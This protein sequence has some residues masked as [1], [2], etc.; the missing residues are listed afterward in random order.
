[1]NSILIAGNIVKRAF[2]SRKELAVML[3]LPIVAVAIMTFMTGT[4]AMQKVSTGIVNLD[5]G[6]Y[7][8]KLISHIK[9]ENS[10]NVIT[11]NY[12]NVG[13]ALKKSEVNIAIVIPSGFSNEIEKGNKVQVDFYNSKIS[14]VSEKLRQDINRFITTI[15]LAD[16]VSENISL[17]SGKPKEEV[18]D[19]IGSGLLKNQLSLKYSLGQSTDNGE[20]RGRMV[21]SIG[22]AIMF[23]MVLI[24]NTMGTMMEDKK[25]LIL[26]RIS[27]FRVRQRDVVAGNLLGSLALGVI[28]LI[29]VTVVVSIVYKIPLGIEMLGLFAILT[30]F[31]I[32]TIGLGIGLSG[33]IK[34]KFNPTL[35]IAAVIFPTSLLGGCLI[36]ESMMPSFLSKL[37]FIVPQKWAMDAIQKL[38][39]GAGFTEILFDIGI[40]LMFG[41]AFASFGVKT[42]KPLSE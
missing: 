37:G 4:P 19:S 10:L 35:V 29:P 21:A 42:I 36:P 25:K 12:D 13:E 15:Y 41:L 27:T 39:G 2:K 23:I 24:F 3:I 40:V 20:E 6:K 5:G 11:M 38:A 32:A 30:C 34:D 9:G 8:E 7:S 31:V 14:E 1:M 22:F 18:A 17:A 28:Q 33:L 26:A 16:E